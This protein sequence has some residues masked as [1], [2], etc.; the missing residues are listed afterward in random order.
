MQLFIRADGFWW[1]SDE[2]G[3]MGDDLRTR[4]TFKV[5][6]M[7]PPVK[8]WEFGDGHKFQ[9]DPM[10]E[11]SKEVTPVCDEVRAKLEG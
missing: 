3:K 7:Q 9:S 5:D 8:G 6:Q 10:M 1:V 11:C 4:V 2:V